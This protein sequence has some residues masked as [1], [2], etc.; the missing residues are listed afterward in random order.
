MQLYNEELY[1]SLIA[2]NLADLKLSNGDD[3]MSSGTAS[4]LNVPIIRRHAS[5]VASTKL[6]P[7][8]RAKH[9]L[10][11]QKRL[12][13][14]EVHELNELERLLRIQEAQHARNV[15]TC[16]FIAIRPPQTYFGMQAHL[17]N[18]DNQHAAASG[19]HSISLFPIAVKS[20]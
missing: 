12:K 15:V 7:A 11:E 14:K 8:S 10:A 17:R 6:S 1:H 19:L 16:S 13:T 3:I 20:Y 4:H 9:V 5:V 18:R 2:D